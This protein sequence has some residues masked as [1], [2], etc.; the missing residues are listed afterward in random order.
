MKLVG[1]I[2]VAFLTTFV[3]GKV[4]SSNLRQ[5]TGAGAQKSLADYENDKCTTIIVGPKAGIEGPMT[6]HTADCADCDFRI[7][8]VPARDWPAGTMRPLYMYKDQY[9]SVVSA[10]RGATWHPDNLQGNAEQ[11]A[12][13]GKESVPS[14]YIPQVAHTFALLEGG[15]AI[16]NEHQVAIGES[17][18]AARF[19][20]VPVTAGGLAKIEVAEMSKIALERSTTAR[21]AIQ[22]MGDLATELGFYAA[23]WSGGDRSSGEAGEA[24]TV[25][26]KTEAWVFHVLGDD[27]GTSAVWAA[28]RLEPDHV[29]ITCDV[30]VYYSCVYMTSSEGQ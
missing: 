14:A 4:G 8:K 20:G 1:S 7:G 11:L 10:N 18:C 16:M 24:L 23:D 17:T 6:T 29:S 3:V 12:A 27:T 5:A 13:W 9:P 15:Y 22:M 21:Q 2:L 28:Q 19:W 30:E 25:I 26:D